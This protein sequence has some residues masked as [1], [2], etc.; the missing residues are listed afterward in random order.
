MDIQELQ[1]KI[2]QAEVQQEKLN[3]EIQE[4]RHKLE[5]YKQDWKKIEREKERQYNL[6]KNRARQIDLIRNRVSGKM[7]SSIIAYYDYMYGEEKWM[8][9]RKEFDEILDTIDQNL[10]AA[11]DYIE[12]LEAQIKEL[13]IQIN[14]WKDE[15]MQLQETQ[16]ED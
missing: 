5:I 14:E 16:G 2:R 15:I 7:L 10:R 8:E 3:R 12:E 1:N 9:I 4:T 11:Y 6:R 13:K